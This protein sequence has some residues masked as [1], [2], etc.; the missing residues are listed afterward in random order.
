[1]QIF[2]LDMERFLSTIVSPVFSEIV[3]VFSELDVFRARPL[4]PILRELYRTKEFR[5]A[6]CLETLEELRA[7]S[8]RKLTLD[9]GAAVR[10]GL[11]DFLP[12]PP[13]VFSRTMAD[14]DDH[15]TQH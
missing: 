13:L 14:N 10:A 3:I 12:C 11:Y 2:V 15:W 1:M 9:T 5:V 8:L 4:E 7:E 6:F